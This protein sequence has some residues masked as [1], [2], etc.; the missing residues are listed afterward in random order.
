MIL[1]LKATALRA[2]GSIAH[3]SE[4]VEEVVQQDSSL[5]LQLYLTLLGD[6]DAVHPEVASIASSL[7]NGAWQPLVRHSY[8]T[9]ARLFRQTTHRE[10]VI[11]GLLHQAVRH[12]GAHALIAEVHAD[13]PELCK[14]VQRVAI[15]TQPV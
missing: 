6:P 1:L 3:I 10:R 9:G 15:E 11:G 8:R 4:L 2:A 12:A 14:Q 13:L 5:R 7:D